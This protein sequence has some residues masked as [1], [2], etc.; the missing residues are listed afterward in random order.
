MIVSRIVGLGALAPVILGLVLVLGQVG[1]A[2]LLGRRQQQGTG[3]GPGSFVV[4]LTLGWLAVSILTAHNFAF[5]SGS[6]AVTALGVEPMIELFVFLCA[7][8]V[9]SSVIRS[10]EPTLAQ[11]RPPIVMFLLPFWVITSATWSDTGPYA[12]ARGVE[13]ATVAVLVWATVA[14]A[15]VDPPSA[16]QVIELYLRWFVRI[17]AGLVALGVAFGPV[18]VPASAENLKR[19]TWVGAHPNAAG[20]VL[21]AAIVIVAAT[22][23]RILRLPPS[24]MLGLGAMF[25]VAMYENHSRTAI[26]C[27]VLGLVIVLGLKGRLTPLIWTIGAPLVGFL[28]VATLHFNGAAVGDYV[29]RDE[30]SDSLATGNGRLRLWSI[31]FRAL[32]TLFDWVFGLGYGISRTLF[33]PEE[34]WALSA[35]NS[36]LAFLVGVGLIGVVLFG[37]TVGY[38]IRAVMAGGLLRNPDT[39]VALVSLLGVMLLNGLAT[40]TLAE[41]ATGFA[42]LYLV[43]A[44]AIASRVAGTVD[45]PGSGEAG[46]RR[47]AAAVGRMP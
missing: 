21:S 11:A 4:P 8:V 12:L 42:V 41:P 9:A 10:L 44:L 26:L 47:D 17:T 45:P 30:G 25:V 46:L 7:G 15:R 20:L 27:L 40:D 35:H 37:I 29:L 39:G 34:P 38:T 6:E 16:N 23:L 28:V 31:G 32:D 14:I 2:R 24:A 33:S 36:I 18:Y 19:F 5:R 43:A 3:I 22:P 13:M 1:V